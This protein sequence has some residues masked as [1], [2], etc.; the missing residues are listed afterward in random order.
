[1]ADLEASLSEAESR[2][3][4]LGKEKKKLEASL[5]ELGA[6]LEEVNAATGEQLRQ[7]EDKVAGLS[8]QVFFF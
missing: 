7:E 8:R 5:A 6:S 1:V 2:V 3:A 4:A